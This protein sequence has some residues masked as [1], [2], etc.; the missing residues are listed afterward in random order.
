MIYNWHSKC[1][2]KAI[3]IFYKACMYSLLN[4]F[5]PYV[6]VDCPYK[7]H[8]RQNNYYK[9]VNKEVMSLLNDKLLVEMSIK[10][11]CVLVNDR[12]LV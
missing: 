6:K 2:H 10:S 1:F 8:K 12:L 5:I 3:I 4:P 11:S 7:V 9:N